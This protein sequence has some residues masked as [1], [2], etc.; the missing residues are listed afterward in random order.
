MKKPKIEQIIN[1]ADN[2]VQFGWKEAIPV[3]ILKNPY[4]TYFSRNFSITLLFL[5]TL[6]VLKIKC[7]LSI[8]F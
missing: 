1:K 6:V 7:F 8:K 4:K 3:T 5:E 2:I